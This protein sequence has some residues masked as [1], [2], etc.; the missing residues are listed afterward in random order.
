M[1][2]I[3]RWTL[4]T[5]DPSS[6]LA[7]GVSRVIDCAVGPFI[8]E[9]IIV[10]GFWRSGTTWVQEQVAAITHA[11]TIFEPLAPSSGDAW[12]GQRVNL[13]RPSAEMFIP[14]SMEMLGP[15][16]KRVIDMALDGRGAGGFALFCRQSAGDALRRRVVVKFTRAS[17]ILEDLLAASGATIIHVHRHPGAIFASLGRAAWEWSF[18]DIRLGLMYGVIPDT[19]SDAVREVRRILLAND[20]SPVRRMGA[21]WAVSE[22]AAMQAAQSQP[23]IFSLG[24]DDLL[25]D[26][27]ILERALAQAGHAT[28][29]AADPAKASPVTS[30]SRLNAD[31]RE[32]R[33]GWLRHLSP[34]ELAELR[35]VTTEIY[36]ACRKLYWHDNVGADGVELD[37]IAQG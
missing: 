27:A 32:R 3:S 6:R 30:A 21:L 37:Q 12:S 17:F 10:N 26:P 28:R 13:H 8:S 31:A 4:A 22:M 14:L 11:K 15:R 9:R 18:Q 20:T 25:A 5:V 23:Q 19:A 16:G 36:P 24:Y 7:K 29:C 33:D 2:P 35:A 34:Q 1:R